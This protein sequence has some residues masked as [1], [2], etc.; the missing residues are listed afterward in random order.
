MN[1]VIYFSL[2]NIGLSGLFGTAKGNGMTPKKS[3]IYCRK[4][5]NKLGIT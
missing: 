4:Q 3:E 2:Q 5:V 1:M